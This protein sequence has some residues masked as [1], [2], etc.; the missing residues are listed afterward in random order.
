[1]HTDIVV[2]NLNTLIIHWKSYKK[3]H[4]ISTINYPTEKK[5]WNDYRIKI[6]YKW[7]IEK[8]LW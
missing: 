4:F 7:S 5:H 3:N 6:W 1:M 2:E 8:M